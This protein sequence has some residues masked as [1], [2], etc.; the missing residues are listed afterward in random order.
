MYLEKG[1]FTWLFLSFIL[2][3]IFG[4]L[5]HE[6]GHFFVAK[7]LGY[8]A[9]IHY[10]STRIIGSGPGYTEHDFWI[11]LGGP[12]QTMFTGSIGLILILTL[13]KTFQSKSNLLLWQW[14]LLFMSLFW[15]RQ[16]ANLF[17]W[18]LGYFIKGRIS[19]AG[20][21]I[22]LARYLGLPNWSIVVFT[23]V[24]G[25]VILYIILFRYV[26]KKQRL[27]FVASGLAGG[28]AGYILWLKY[29][30]KLILP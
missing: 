9:V 21:E 17:T 7:W 27:T 1:L 28:T 29:L 20:D 19:K 15:L 26:P 25:S 16:P 13:Y 18:V 12:V 8:D 23:A 10:G 6:A 3:T 24:I 5:F 30:G 14:V 11:T 2:A 4:T 22:Q